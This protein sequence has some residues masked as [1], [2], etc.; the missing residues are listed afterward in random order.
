MAAITW[1]NVT[2]L[3]AGLS[4]TPPATQTA[5]LAYVHEVVAAARLGGEEAQRTKMARALLAA[6]FAKVH[7]QLAAGQATGPVTSRSIGGISK[8]WLAPSMTED[9]LQRTGHGASYLLVVRTAPLCQ[10]FSV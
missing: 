9:G 2:D 5:I 7:E 4:A 8:S 3:E 10:G 6:H 1:V